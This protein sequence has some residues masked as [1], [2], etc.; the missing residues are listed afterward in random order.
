MRRVLLAACAVA[1][2]AGCGKNAAKQEAQDLADASAAGGQPAAEFDRPKDAGAANIRA[3]RAPGSYMRFDRGVIVDSTGFAEPTAVASLFIPYGW[4]TQGGVFW[5]QQ[6]MCTN[7]YNFEWSATAPDG[8]SGVAVVPHT[9]WENNDYGAAATTPGCSSA[10]YSSV[11]EYLQA[12]AP[13]AR[14]GAQVIEYRDR[15]DILKAVG[16]GGVQRTPMPMGESRLWT[17]AGEVTIS[18]EQNGRPMRAVLA[19]AVNFS[20]MISDY[21]SMYAN[22]PTIQ[23]AP[24]GQT[25]MSTLSAYANPGWF[26]YGPADSFNPALF[27]AIRSSIRPNPQWAAKIANHNAQIGRVAIEEGRKRAAMIAESNAEISRIRQEV[28]DNQQE[29]ADRRAREFGE[30]IKGVETYADAD[31]PGGQVELSHFYNNAWRLNDGTYVLSND[32][33]FDPWQD[34]QVEGKKLEAVR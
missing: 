1:L 18:F 13:Q 16:G 27:E 29:S 33:G 28:W 6:F 20:A 24:I 8:L 23:G 34:L 17:E 3:E 30:M 25:R 26:A 22:D 15:P 5:G 21:S 32:A 11:R 31:A 14:P 9:K 2:V 19:A 7:G 10:P 4:R 12:L